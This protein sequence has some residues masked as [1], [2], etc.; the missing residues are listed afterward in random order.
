[1]ELFAWFVM[2]G[3]VNTKVRLNK[4]NLLMANQTQCDLCNKHTKELE[5]L[6]FTYEFSWMVWSY[7]LK[8]WSVSW[9]VPNDR[10][11]LFYAWMAMIMRNS[12]EKNWIRIFFAVIWCI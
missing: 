5:Y 8:M 7:W 12:K 10:R 11:M 1:M 2:V 6:F 3:R 4:L 9:V